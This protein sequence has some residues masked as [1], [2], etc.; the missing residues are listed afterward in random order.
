VVPLEILCLVLVCQS[1]C[2][3][4]FCNLSFK[5]SVNAAFEVRDLRGRVSGVVRTFAH[6]GAQRGA[7]ETEG[8][9]LVEDQGVA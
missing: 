4:L 1:R 6:A 5:S 3:G 8:L 9:A 7:C 2:P